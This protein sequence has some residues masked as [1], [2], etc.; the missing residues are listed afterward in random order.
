MGGTFDMAHL[1]SGVSSTPLLREWLERGL[2][3]PGGPARYW[4][5]R[6][7]KPVPS[8]VGYG[9]SDSGLSRFG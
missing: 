5:L 6:D 8:G 9:F 2:R 4:V 3:Q 7:Q 1:V